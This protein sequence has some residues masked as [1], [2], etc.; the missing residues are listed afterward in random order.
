MNRFISIMLTLYVGFLGFYANA[1]TINYYV[2]AKQAMPFQIADATNKN[3]DQ[4]KHTGIV[5]DI[6]IEIFANSPYEIKYHTYPF[7]R[8]VSLLEAGGEANWLTY[9][10]P[11]WNSVQAINLSKLA[12]YNVNH[13]LLSSKK[14][15]FKFD[16]MT[17]VKDK[18]FVLLHGFNYP[19]LQPF[20]DN[21]SIQTLRVKDYAAAFRILDKMP[22]DAVFV[23][24]KSRIK[25][26]LKQQSRDIHNYQLQDFASVIPNYPIYLALDPKMDKK[27]QYFINKR[28]K[29]LH[30]S[31]SIAKIINQY[32]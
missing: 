19:Q 30:A 8:M 29:E 24:M 2:I 18:I 17:N 10:S 11:G 23:E 32:I 26:N 20:I 27:I 25:Y 22:N 4:I 6:V 5:C 1:E 16:N 28:L 7:N 21:G 15:T 14:S 12:I 3:G 31:G 13:S 9:G